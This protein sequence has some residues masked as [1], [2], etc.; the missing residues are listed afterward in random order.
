MFFSRSLP[1]SN[2]RLY[3]HVFDTVTYSYIQ[4]KSLWI[5]SN[6]LP[7]PIKSNR[8]INCELKQEPSYLLS[9]GMLV[10]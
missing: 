10:L 6:H 8:S 9:L 4:F 5:V 1:T 7:L 2:I 3:T